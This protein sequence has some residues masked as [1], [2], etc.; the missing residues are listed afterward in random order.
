[1][2]GMFCF[3]G[4]LDSKPLK[5]EEQEKLFKKLKMGDVG[6]RDE[7]IYRNLRLVFLVCKKYQNL[8]HDIN[9]LISI[10]TIGLIKAIDNFDITQEVQ[11]STYGV[12]MII[13]RS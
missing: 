5:G 8:G 3:E 6:V 12:P 4:N 11:F 2:S 7:L 9:D 13:R 10:G 1:M